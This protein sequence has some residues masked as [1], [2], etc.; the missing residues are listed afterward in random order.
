MAVKPIRLLG[1]PVLRRKCLPVKQMVSS[2]TRQTIRDL[3]D[4][5][6]DFRSKKGFG[7]AIAA[8][9]IG[10][11]RRIIVMRLNTRIVLINPTITRRSAAMTT[12]WDDCFSFPDLLVKVRRHRSISL[13]YFDY[14]GTLVH[15]NASGVLNELLQHEIDHLD[16]ILAVDRAISSRH[17]ILRS[18]FAQA[19]E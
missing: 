17:I 15:A 13:S 19:N 5:L 2:A 11:S 12:V 10:V 14:F 4:T 6:D 7:H 1:N 8:P 9:Q 16:G 3:T 18:E